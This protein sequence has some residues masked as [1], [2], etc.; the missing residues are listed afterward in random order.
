[1]TF[2]RPRMMSSDGATLRRLS[3]ALAGTV[4]VW[5]APAA[6]AQTASSSSEAVLPASAGSIEGRGAI[7]VASGISNQELNSAVIALGDAALATGIVVQGLKNSGTTGGDALAGIAGSA[8]VGS[9]GMLAVNVAAGHD[10]Q[11]ANLAVVAIGI[12]VAAVSES[13]LAQSRASQQPN[14]SPDP[15]PQNSH[16]ADLSEQAFSGSTG[17]VQSNL[18]GGERN[19]SSNSFALT[20]LGEDP[21]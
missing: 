15:V 12:E 17:L 10:N 19:S 3:A 18:I 2:A 5:I 21:L 20:V 6:I 9:S 14:G 7:N 11:L 8:L 4:L 13:M 16:A 1:M